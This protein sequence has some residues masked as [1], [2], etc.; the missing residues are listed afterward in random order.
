MT[1]THTYTVYAYVWAQIELEIGYL[2]W[3][4]DVNGPHSCEIREKKNQSKFLTWSVNESESTQMGKRPTLIRIA[5]SRSTLKIVEPVRRDKQ[6]VLRRIIK[7]SSKPAFPPY[8]LPGLLPWIYT[9]GRV[10]PALVCL[11]HECKNMIRS[12]VWHKT[13]KI[14]DEFGRSHIF[15][16]NVSSFCVTSV[17]SIS[18]FSWTEVVSWYPQCCMFRA[19]AYFLSIHD[20]QLIIQDWKRLHLKSVFPSL[21][22]NWFKFISIEFFLHS[23]TGILNF[24]VAYMTST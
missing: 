4:V 18:F 7:L 13:D 16:E 20:K 19:S 17:K 14:P 22:K 12:P 8:S 3:N 1:H 2:G 5:L 24:F 10:W 6:S 15:V 21:F 11:L 23:R 9:K